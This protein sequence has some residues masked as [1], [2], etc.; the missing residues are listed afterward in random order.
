[1]WDYLEY[2]PKSAMITPEAKEN[3][4]YNEKSGKI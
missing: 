4:T 3:L 1:L 2:L